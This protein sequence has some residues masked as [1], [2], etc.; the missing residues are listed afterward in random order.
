MPYLGDSQVANEIDYRTDTPLQSEIGTGCLAQCILFGIM[1]IDVEFDGTIIINP[2][3]TTLSNKTEIK[4]LKLRGKNIDISVD[5]DKFQV[6][7]NGNKYS[8]DIGHP[9]KL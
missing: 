4:G 9:V 7:A 8:S 6:F 5:G 2:K 1:G 3:K